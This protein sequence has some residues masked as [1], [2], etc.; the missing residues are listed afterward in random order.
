M[1]KLLLT[2][3]ATRLDVQNTSGEIALD[4]TRKLERKEI[5]LTL[6][7]WKRDE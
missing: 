6:K 7:S 3:R 2:C 4:I 1:V 5:F